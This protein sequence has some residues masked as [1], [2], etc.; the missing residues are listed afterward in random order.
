LYPSL[1]ELHT[2]ERKWVVGIAQQTT[3]PNG[4]MDIIIRR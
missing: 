1:K 3:H 4:V 2:W